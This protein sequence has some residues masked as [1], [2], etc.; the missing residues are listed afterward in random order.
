[1]LID[2]TVSALLED[3]SS[4]TPT[5]GGRSASALSGAMGVSLVAMVAGMTKTRAGSEDSRA[6]L[7]D[8]K[9]R[10]LTLRQTLTS[11]VDR[12]A[13]AYNLVVS[14][15]KKPKLTDDDKA[16]RKQ[17][18]QAAMRQATEVPLETMV[19]CADA[20]AIAVPV[21]QHGN[22]AAIS[23]LA[24]GVDLLTQ[25]LQGGFYNVESNLGAIGDAQ[26][27]DAIT[28]NARA[29]LTRAHDAIRAIYQT[30]GFSELM[31]ATAARAGSSHG[32]LPSARG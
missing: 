7:D 22:P 11:L 12:D 23:D 10:Q 6:L 20:L 3:F 32:Q 25:A 4:P 9:T 19:A 8:A 31:K 30:Q 16:A 2:K 15:Y 17:A 18:I 13:D 28:R 26:V 14:A 27:V 1:M 24:V 5:P 21:A 29:V